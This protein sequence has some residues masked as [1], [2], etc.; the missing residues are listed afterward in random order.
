MYHRDRALGLDRGADRNLS[1]WHERLGG[2]P[3]YR[4]HVS[5][6]SRETAVRRGIRAEEACGR[7]PPRP[8][9][10]ASRP[11]RPATGQ[12]PLADAPLE[13]TLP[14]RPAG[15]T[16]VDEPHVVAAA[17]RVDPEAA[18][19]LEEGMAAAG[20]RC[21]PRGDRERPDP[22]DRRMHGGAPGGG[23]SRER[24]GGGPGRTDGGSVAQRQTP[25]SRRTT[26]RPVR[27]TREVADWNG[28]RSG[29]CAG[30][31]ARTLPRRRTVGTQQRHSASRPVCPVLPRP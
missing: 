19:R 17:V 15:E 8:P 9:S 11:S 1:A 26:P 12:I 29:Y 18:G 6:R 28:P 30:V 20:T 24:A 23:S 3:A 27:S 10:P 2:R 22:P 14:A 7:W 25:T 4:A 16:A 5:F 13:R 21:G 31:V